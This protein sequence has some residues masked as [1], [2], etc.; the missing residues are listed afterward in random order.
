MWSILYFSE[1]WSSYLLQ[2]SA[3]F[4]ELRKQ[5]VAELKRDLEKSENSIGLVTICSQSIFEVQLS[6]LYF[7]L[8]VDYPRYNLCRLFFIQA[9]H[10]FI[11]CQLFGNVWSSFYSSRSLQSVIQSLS[12]SK[13]VDGSSECRTSHTESCSHSKDHEGS[14]MI[15]GPDDIPAHINPPM[16]GCAWRMCFLTYFLPPLCLCHSSTA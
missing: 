16:F 11:L 10:C 4:E 7:V 6:Y 13:H 8:I 2:C 5:R 12:N 3:W 1:F 14:V 15:T 9:S